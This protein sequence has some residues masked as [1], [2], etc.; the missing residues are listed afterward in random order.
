MNRFEQFLTAHMWALHPD[1][2]AALM[3]W[4]HGELGDPKALAASF[5]SLA[6]VKPAKASTGAIAVIPVQGVLSNRA[7]VFSE[8]FGWG[9]YQGLTMAVQAAMGD[10]SISTILLDIDSPGG[11][12]TGCMELCA[13]L[14]AAREKKPVL[15]IANSFAASAAY[16]IGSQASNFWVTPSGELGSIGVYAMHTDFSK[17]LEQ[18]GVT[19]T[20]IQAGKFKTECNQYQPLGADAQARVQAEVD[21]FYEDFVR[22]V[23]AGRKTTM[24]AVRSDMGEGRMMRAEPA[25]AAKMVDR[26]GTMQ[27]LMGRLGIKPGS[28]AARAEEIAL[29]IAAQAGMP[30]PEAYRRRFDFAG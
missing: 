27:D 3:R 5:P 23:A 17:M 14:M 4:T 18:D 8:I 25:K 11:E 2:L 21:S 30:D 28:A 10:P 26:I 13:E 16:W 7:D 22:A 24:K 12:V 1:A 9:T 19:V 15:A 6:A 20:F 29:P